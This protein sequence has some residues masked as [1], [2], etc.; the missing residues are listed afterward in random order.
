MQTHVDFTAQGREA[1]P[2]LLRLAEN[3]QR[4]IEH[5]FE[6]TEKDILTRVHSQSLQIAPYSP[7]Y[8]A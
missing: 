3:L 7:V 8:T 1:R 6:M 2:E 4:R 5:L